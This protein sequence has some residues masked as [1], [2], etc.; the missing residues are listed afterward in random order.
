MA[1]RHDMKESRVEKKNSFIEIFI[2]ACLARSCIRSLDG[3][4]S[5]PQL[6]RPCRLSEPSS[7]SISTLTIQLLHVWLQY[8]PDASPKSSVKYRVRVVL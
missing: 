4:L 8:P 5:R 3:E 7:T 6:E 1:G 2:C